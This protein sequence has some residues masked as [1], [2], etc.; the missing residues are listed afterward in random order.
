MCWSNERWKNKEMTFI[1]PPAQTKKVDKKENR[2][3]IFIED[4]PVSPSLIRSDFPFLKIVTPP[5]LQKAI[6]N[7]H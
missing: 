4:L 3:L 5:I 6:H 7:C 1:I 2:D